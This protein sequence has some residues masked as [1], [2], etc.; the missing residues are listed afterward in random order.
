MEEDCLRRH[1]HVDGSDG[2]ALVG[3][4]GGTQG[5]H[6]RAVAVVA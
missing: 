6:G 1:R 3:V 4:A 2:M 5:R